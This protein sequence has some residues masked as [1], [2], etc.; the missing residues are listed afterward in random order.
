MFRMWKRSF[1]LAST[2]FSGRS[3]PENSCGVSPP[4]VRRAVAALFCG[5]QQSDSGKSAKPT[6]TKATNHMKGDQKSQS[7]WILFVFFKFTFRQQLCEIKFFL[8]VTVITALFL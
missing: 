8:A 1:Y 2:H 6:Q 3:I 7:T 4:L 5:N